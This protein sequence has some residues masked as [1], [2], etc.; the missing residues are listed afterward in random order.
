MSHILPLVP[1]LL[2][3]LV[4][5]LLLLRPEMPRARQLSALSV[6]GLLLA[7]L[8]LAR[9]TAGGAVGVVAL[10]NWPA[11]YGIVL[12]ADSLAAFLVLL[13]A[14]LAV[15]ALW[16]AT[17]GARPLDAAGPHFH[18]L[19]QIQLAG[20]AGAFLTGDLF[21]LFVFF[22]ILLIASY[23][24][25]AFGL[26]PAQV[27]AVLPYA[28]L[29][30]V[31]SALFLVALGLVYGMLGTLNMAD[32][33]EILPDVPARNL[34]LVRLAFLLMAL[35][36]LMKAA[37]MPFGL[38]LPPSYSAASAPV[39]VLFAILTKVG[40]IAMLRLAVTVVGASPAGV[41]LFTPWLPALALAT[42]LLGMVQLLAARR[43]VGIACAAVTLSSGSLLFALAD[44][45]QA[46]VAALLFYLVQSVLATAGLFLLAGAIDQARRGEG[47]RLLRGAPIEGT[48]A[49]LAF[50]LLAVTLAGLPPLSGFVGKLMLMQGAGTGGWRLA[51]WGLL[52]AS[53]LVAA[54]MLARAGSRLFWESREGLATVRLSPSPP[55]LLLV[56]AGPALA[57]FAAPVAGWADRTA[58]QLVDGL[59]YREAVLGSRPVEREARP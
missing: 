31:G 3:L 54:T 44:G 34:A 49:M 37:L 25:L 41:D 56:A 58:G 30:L 43:L 21:N 5:G 15:P 19:F 18:V 26:A 10:G 1:V 35:V 27:R 40:I 14:G 42:L 12:V 13:L 24:L 22:E 9:A 59:A 57:L 55:L 11:P 51:W 28:A 29:N 7:G 53:G 6:A 38:W 16:A 47:D 39:A 2:P 20:I 32:I 52:L 45:G 36:F 23:A 50:A 46:A 8:L 48:G 17:H 4:A 33:A